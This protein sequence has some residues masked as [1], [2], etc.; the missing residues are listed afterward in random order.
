MN[1]K[2][3][4]T[5]CLVV[6]LPL[7]AACSSTPGSGKVPQGAD[8][9]TEILADGTKIFK[10]IVRPV[11]PEERP[12][13]TGPAANARTSGDCFPCEPG[14]QRGGMGGR[15]DKPLDL[16]AVATTMLTDNHY[17]RDGFVVLEQY[18][19]N[20]S[21]ILRGECRDAADDSDRA[22]FSP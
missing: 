15:N 5:Q 2:S 18:H 14:Q 21:Q 3:R 4:V 11:A 19:Q 22:R 7:F 20:R 17:C 1:K 6:L 13:M 16:K 10:V 8:F 9:S 12:A